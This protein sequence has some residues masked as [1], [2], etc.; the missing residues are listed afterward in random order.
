MYNYL[1]EKQTNSSLDLFNSVECYFGSKLLNF[2]GVYFYDTIELKK[3][4]IR[5]DAL[6]LVFV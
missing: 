4:R 1:F 5:I 6:F 3:K 2:M